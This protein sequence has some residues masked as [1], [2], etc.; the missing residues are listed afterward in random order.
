MLYVR[1]K[2]ICQRSLPPLLSG[3]EHCQKSF[4]L[5]KLLFFCRTAVKNGST[6]K[7]VLLPSLSIFFCTRS[8]YRKKCISPLLNIVLLVVFLRLARSSPVCKNP[9]SSV[10]SLLSCSERKKTSRSSSFFPSPLRQA[11]L[12]FRVCCGTLRYVFA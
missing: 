7:N 1:K 3:C 10:A 8:S 11:R 5:R 12:Q 6:K 4:L 9:S 2:H